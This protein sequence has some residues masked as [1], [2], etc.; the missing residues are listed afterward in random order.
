MGQ[1]KYVTAS[2]QK[3]KQGGPKVAAPKFGTIAQ[4]VLIYL[5][6]EHNATITPLRIQWS[7]MD[8]NKFWLNQAI[9]NL[10]VWKLAIQKG[11][12]KGQKGSQSGDSKTT[13]LSKLV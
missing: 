6:D 1:C 4:K 8:I 9:L 12:L 5:S 7:K 3:K 2:F 13:S 10:L 11:H